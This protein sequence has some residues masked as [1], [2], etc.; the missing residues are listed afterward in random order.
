MS[1]RRETHGYTCGCVYYTIGGLVV[2]AKFCA[3]HQ[4]TR[5][6]LVEGLA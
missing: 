2:E 4:V 3:R 5:E 1:A 6:V